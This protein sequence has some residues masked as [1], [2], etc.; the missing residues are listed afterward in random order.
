M[1]P[2]RLKN[3]PFWGVGPDRERKLKGRRD[4]VLEA[5][6]GYVEHKL[7]P[8]LESQGNTTN[9]Q[10]PNLADMAGLEEWDGAHDAPFE[11]KFPNLELTSEDFLQ[12][13]VDAYDMEVHTAEQ[14]QRLFEAW[15]VD[16][17][18]VIVGGLARLLTNGDPTD[19]RAR[20]D[21]EALFEVLQAPLPLWTAQL[22]ARSIH[23]LAPE[24][25]TE[26]VDE[27]ESEILKKELR[28][29]SADVPL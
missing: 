25:A 18:A 29:N 24:F 6:R 10:R 11:G 9:P 3:N 1:I 2:D 4:L 5:I 13:I 12:T 22:V 19:E 23:D 14:R 15:A 20:D 7:V 8:W 27:V 21:A 17:A 28:G 26:K 16:T